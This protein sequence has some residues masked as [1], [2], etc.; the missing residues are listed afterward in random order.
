MIK[1]GFIWIIAVL[2]LVSTVFAYDLSE[3]PDIFLGKR[4][5]IVIGSAAKAEDMAGAINVAVTLVQNGI[6]IESMLDKDIDD[7]YAQNLVVV[8]GPC[9]NSVAA[10]LMGY[11]SNCLEGFEVGKGRIKIYEYGNGKIALFL[12]GMTAFDTRM[13][14]L[15]VTNYENLNLSG[16]EMEVIEPSISNI[17]IRK[18][19]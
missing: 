10:K 15:A 5:T 7:I 19:D 17:I 9:I 8:G 6:R 1:K 16:Q 13:S 4:A 12:A 18:S 11:P 14:T 3:F 2:L